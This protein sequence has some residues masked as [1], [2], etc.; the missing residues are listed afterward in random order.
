VVC[1]VNEPPVDEFDHL[2]RGLVLFAY[3]H[4]AAYPAAAEALLGQGVAAVAYET[5]QASSR[6]LPL[7]T[8]VAEVAGRM[9]PR[10]GAR[11]LERQP[12]GRAGRSTWSA[13]A[14]W[15]ANAA[16]WPPASPRRMPR[17]S[18][19]WGCGHARLPVASKA[20]APRHPHE[21]VR[22]GSAGSALTQ[23]VDQ[24]GLAHR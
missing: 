24:L 18:A 7:L 21:H 10:V 9:A 4:L 2:R 22:R 19:E 6:A 23:R 12:G 1:T 16:G 8:P 20:R 5:V 11:L 3:L 13:E 15:S 14:R 17:N